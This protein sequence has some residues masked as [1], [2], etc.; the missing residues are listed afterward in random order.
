[1]WQ[2]GAKD[3]RP[4]GGAVIGGLLPAPAQE[5]RVHY[6]YISSGNGLTLCWGAH[7]PP[8]R[9]RGVSLFLY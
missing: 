2:N 6:A 5:A 8:F 9:R 4:E 1:M 3:A 7:R